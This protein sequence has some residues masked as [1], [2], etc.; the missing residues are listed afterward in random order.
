[1]LLPGAST[2]CQFYYLPT[3][4]HLKGRH[5][6]KVVGGRSPCRPA[7]CQQSLSHE[8]QGLLPGLYLESLGQGLFHQGPG[9]QPAVLVEV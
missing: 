5:G 7:A 2:F 8:P 3:W 1:M 6:W 4:V 9:W